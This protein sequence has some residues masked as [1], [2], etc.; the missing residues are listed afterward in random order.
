MA[1]KGRNWP[2]LKCRDFT[3][4]REPTFQYACYA[5]QYKLRIYDAVGI[6]GGWYGT[7]T[8][9]REG[10]FTLATGEMTWRWDSPKIGSAHV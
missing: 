7:D 6:F 5:K 1:H 4:S 2:Y 8:Y 10:T 9:S 3:P